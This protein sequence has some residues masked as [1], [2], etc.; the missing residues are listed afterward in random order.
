[1]NGQISGHLSIGGIGIGLFGL[2]S[3]P[4]TPAATSA[5]AKKTY[6][7]HIEEFNNRL[8]DVGLENNHNDEKFSPIT[9]G[10]N[11]HSVPP[12]LL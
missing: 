3:F 7:N 1:M 5:R 9:L 8:D 4:K 12:I 6:Y 2:S 10:I 11:N